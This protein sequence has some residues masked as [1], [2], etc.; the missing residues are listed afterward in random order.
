MQVQSKRGDRLIYKV[1]PGSH[2]PSVGMPYLT[3]LGK[4]EDPPA[5]SSSF[6][7]A[8]PRLFVFVKLVPQLNK[9]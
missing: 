1:V 5:K 4:G 2:E 6:P 3:M 9:Y 8:N 7:R